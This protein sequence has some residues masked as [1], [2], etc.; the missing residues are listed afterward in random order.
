MVS[1]EV[2]TR[3]MVCHVLA[4]EPIECEATTV[5]TITNKQVHWTV[6]TNTK[7][8]QKQIK[9]I[10]THIHVLRPTHKS[11]YTLTNL[12]V[13]YQ[14]I[15]QVSV[16]VQTITSDSTTVGKL[17]SKHESQ[18]VLKSKKVSA[19][20]LT[21]EKVS[22]LRVKKVEEE[23]SQTIHES[24]KCIGT[25]GGKSIRSCHNSCSESQSCSKSSC[26]SAS[27]SNC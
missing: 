22:L 27:Q 16:T 1:T 24:I 9:Q 25:K 17:T 6:L 13:S 3:V 4:H 21:N 11:F 19:R 2:W 5:D 15:G 12:C 14:S 8:P 23:V 7:Q 18:R 10:H 26:K 20:T